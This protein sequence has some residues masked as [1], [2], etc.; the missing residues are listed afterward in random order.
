MATEKYWLDSDGNVTLAGN[1]SGA[2]VP[3]LNVPRV[4]LAVSAITVPAGSSQ[5]SVYSTPSSAAATSCVM[6]NP[7]STFAGPRIV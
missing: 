1:W 6:S 5:P 3:T 2:S 4:A 7:V